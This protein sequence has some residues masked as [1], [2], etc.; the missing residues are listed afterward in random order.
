MEL[1]RLKNL[2]HNIDP[3]AFI[4]TSIIKEAAGG[5]LKRRARH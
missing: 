4:F 2:V 3:K 1:R 5:V